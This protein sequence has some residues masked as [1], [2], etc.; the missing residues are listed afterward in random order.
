MVDAC[1]GPDCGCDRWRRLGKLRLPWISSLDA[2]LAQ[3]LVTL[4][5]RP[6]P[7]HLAIPA[8]LGP[9]FL[10]HRGRSLTFLEVAGGASV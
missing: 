6:P 4:R 3:S 5:M 7:R 8:P 9:S 10:D 2:I 1:A